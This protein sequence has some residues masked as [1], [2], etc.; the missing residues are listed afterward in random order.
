MSA[1]SMYNSL[2]GCVVVILPII[3]RRLF[4]MIRYGLGCK[5]ARS[6]FMGRRRNIATQGLKKEYEII[7]TNALR[8][9]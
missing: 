5:I 1:G 2:V 8:Q 7:L 9:S 4:E 3:F 6:I